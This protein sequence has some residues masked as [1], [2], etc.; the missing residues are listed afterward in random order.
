L[1]C[2][3]VTEQKETMVDI[4]IPMSHEN[5]A[6]PVDPQ[7]FFQVSKLLMKSNDFFDFQL[8]F[9]FLFL[10]LVH[11]PRVLSGGESFPL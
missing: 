2:E 10:E 7:L 5:L 4:A 8:I 11:Y 1:T 6:Q 3:T 9:F